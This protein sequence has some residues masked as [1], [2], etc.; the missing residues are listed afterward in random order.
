MTL[1]EDLKWRGLIQ[2][3][4]SPDLIEK[5]NNGGLTFYIGTDPTADS[6]HIGH[7]SSFLI[8]KRLAKYG[9]HPLLLVGGATGLIGD[10]KPDAERPMI[11]KEEVEK[12]Y[13]GLKK[14]AE[15]IFG[16]EVVN[17]WDWTKDI[18]VID[19]LRDYGKYFNV[20]YMLAKDKVKT[21]LDSGITYAEFSYMILQAL[22]FM[23]LF[24]TRNCT[25]QVAGSDQWGNITSGIELIRKKLDKEAYGMVM[26][27]VTD[28]NGK[29]FGKTEGNALWLDKNKTSSYALYQ[30]LINLE[31]S[32]I[33]KYLKM[34]TFLSKEEIESIEKEH[35][36]HPELRQAHKALAKEII[37]DIHGEAE[38]E[39]AVKISESLF[40]EKIKELSADDIIRNLKDIP[41]YQTAETNLIDLLVNSKICSS[42]REAK[43]MI[44]NNAISIN[45]IKVNDLDKQIT[46]NDFIDNKVMLIK[47]GKKNY[48]MIIFK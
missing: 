14:Q 4:S 3:I 45:S 1:Y 44:T 17:N 21:R 8:S 35:N 38:Y 22:D 39:K 12:N 13:Q 47:K 5:L 19:F 32:M 37:T 24:E 36:E 34:L 46:K 31:D 6:M 16:F 43:E 20:N 18:N 40:S 25:L 41:S 29:K 9:H 2:D 11:T 10:P 7:Y 30:Y 48:F 28:S 33:I 42:K 15:E 23:Y 27:L 26:P